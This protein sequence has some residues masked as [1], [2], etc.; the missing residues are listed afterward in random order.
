MTL[1][2]NVRI[3]LGGVLASGKSMIA[4]EVQKPEFRDILLAI[5]DGNPGVERNVTVLEEVVDAE[6]FG[7]YYDD[8]ETYGFPFQVGCFNH[9]LRREKEAAETGGI[10]ILVQPIEGDRWMYGAANQANMGD[11]FPI[12]ADLFGLMYERIDPPDVYVYLRIA[13]GDVGVLQKRIKKRARPS[14]Q[15]MLEDPSYLLKLIKFAD[16]LYRE[17]IKDRPVIE[18]DVGQMNLTPEGEVD[19]D[20]VQQTLEYIADQMRRRDIVSQIPL[21]LNRWLAIDP[22]QAVV[23]AHGMRDRLAGYLARRQQGISHAGSIGLGKTGWT[24]ILASDLGI[25]PSYELD[26]S[27]DLEGDALLAKFVE[28]KRPEDCYALQRHRIGKFLDKRRAM[29]ETGRSFVEDKDPLEDPEAFHGLLLDQD[30]LTRSQYDEL[31]GLWRS[32]AS[33]G[34]ATN[35]LLVL[36]GPAE[37]SYAR[38]FQRGR[39]QE[40]EGGGG[41]DLERDLRPLAR[42]HYAEFGRRV[43]ESPLI[44]GSILTLDAGRVNITDEVHRGFLYEKMLQ[45][46]RAHD[47]D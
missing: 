11:L 35:M 17:V 6:L 36:K 3:A 30:L 43:R 1:A 2:D 20:F 18:V 27:Q 14:E 37:L 15:G 34:P 7:K 21:G 47:A 16:H 4:E 19:P 28:H 41:W 26:G 25:L 32:A 40:V 44:D 12:Y 9:R 45:A 8:P 13:P 24:G 42:H 10:V 33:E 5:L 39:K 22:T 29:R 38:M 46:F 23:E 31:Q